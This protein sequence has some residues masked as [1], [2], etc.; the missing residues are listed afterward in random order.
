MPVLLIV[1]VSEKEDEECGK[2]SLL[3]LVNKSEEIGHIFL[4]N[5]LRTMAP[6]DCVT[7][8]TPKASPQSLGVRATLESEMKVGVQIISKLTPT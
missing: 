7:P 2:V 5:H 1:F 3:V 6:V 8:F 4:I